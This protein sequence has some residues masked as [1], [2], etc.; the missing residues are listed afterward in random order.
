VLGAYSTRQRVVEEDDVQFMQSIGNLLSTTTHIRR[1][2]QARRDS[3]ARERAVVCTAVDGMIVIDEQG[4]IQSTNPA[5]ERM[6]G[7]K[8]AE[9]VG[10]NISMLMPEP[11]RQEHD[12]YISNY[13]R[14]RVPKIIGV[15]REVVGR[16]K[17]GST[18]P[19]DLS[20]SEFLLSDRRMFTGIV[21]D[22]TQRRKLERE[23]LEISGN[24]QRRIGQ[25]LHDGLCQQL[26]AV[27]FAS[28]SL[29]NRL[30]RAAPQEV[31]YVTKI[32]SLVDETLTQARD[33]ARGLNPVDIQPDGLIRA[34][35]DLCE[36]IS[37]RFAVTC[38]V[39]KDGSIIVRDNTVA[40]HLYRI[41]QE[42]TSNAIRHGKAK[43]IDID[44]ESD[45]DQ[46][47][48]SIH[49]NGSGIPH[50]IPGRRPGVGMQIMNYRAHLIG[51]SFS[52]RAGRRG[53]TVVSCVLRSSPQASQ[54]S[55][56]ASEKAAEG[57]ETATT[58]KATGTTRRRR[59]ARGAG[60]DQEK[61]AHR[62]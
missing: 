31:P 22:I 50:R 27:S 1:A 48:L 4:H 25:D 43:R 59:R 28:E 42:A 56:D 44:L 29:A 51:G 34:L 61:A 62:R 30:A 46:L 54:R 32:A 7:Y 12:T 36:K 55:A 41:A 9:M 26:P 3:E 10:H 58:G 23:I 35:E 60:S 39:R 24:E 18:F 6:F 57:N 17:D 33:L 2:E 19:M 47:T 21:H 40:T 5:T 53:G 45:G 13:L 20:V 38:R 14:T 8:S 52:V 16:R 37:E 11:Y 49:D 15:G